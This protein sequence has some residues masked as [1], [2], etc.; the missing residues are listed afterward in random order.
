MVT[1][2][3]KVPSENCVEI[4]TTLFSIHLKLNGVSIEVTIG[5]SW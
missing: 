3:D 2:F 1:G 5:L 4:V